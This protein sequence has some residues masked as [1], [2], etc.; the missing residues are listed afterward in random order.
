MAG[1]RALIARARR[2][3]A[4]RVHPMLAKL[5]GEAGWA[6]LQADAEAGI[7][8]GRYD[9]RDIPVVIGAIRLWLAC[10]PRNQ[11]N[12]LA[13]GRRSDH[14][15][16]TLSAIRTADISRIADGARRRAIR[17]I[18]GATNPRGRCA[19]RVVGGIPNRR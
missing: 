18:G 16:A 15:A 8:A 17:T 11:L 10:P 5:G 19:I 6:A 3:E 2:L 12:L 13:V 7:A 4:C 9:N 1:V 14:G